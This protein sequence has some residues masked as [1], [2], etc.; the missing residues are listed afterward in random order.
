VEAARPIFKQIVSPSYL[1]PVSPEQKVKALKYLGA[2]YAV[3]E[4]LDS[5]EMFF[6]AALEFD[7]FTDLDATKFSGSE[8]N[9][10]NSAKRKVFKI[11]VRPIYP[12]VVD[13]Q[14]DS[15]AYRFSMVSTHRA[16]MKV[17]LIRQPDGNLKETLFEGDIDGG[18][19][20]RWSGLMK[21]TGGKIVDSATYM[22]RVEATSA[23]LAGG[24][25]APPATE[26]QFLKI[27]HSYAP[28][29]D[30]LPT[31]TDSMLLPA[32][33]PA[34]APWFDLAKGVMVGVAAYA[35]PAA[36]LSADLSWQ[37]HAIV[38]AAA[39]VVSGAGSFLYRSKKREIP[40]NVAENRRRQQQRTDFNDGVRARNA[41]SIANTKL[42][43]TSLNAR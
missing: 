10:F 34:A 13:P 22:L 38:G 19:E 35:F 12:A 24:A 37:I 30:T 6:S 43:I 4:K 7:P 40:E 28:L 11:G 33:I 17:E 36:L 23:L 5:A 42:I 41:F 27:E 3:L 2:S 31:L 21:S 29:E 20:Y 16:R 15:T 1:A 32:R 25:T 39:G 14:V 9:V 26:T 8:L 18:K